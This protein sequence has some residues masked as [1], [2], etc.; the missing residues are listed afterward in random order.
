MGKAK[1]KK[2]DPV[3]AAEL[4]AA[5]QAKSSKKKDEK[6]GGW[7]LSKIGTNLFTLAIVGYSC[8]VGRNMYGIFQPDFPDEVN[9]RP[10]TKYSNAVQPG[11]PLRARVWLGDAVPSSGRPSADVAPDWEFEFPYSDSAF[12][13]ETKTVPVRVPEGLLRRKSNIHI[14][15]EVS[16]RQAQRAFA[17]SHGQFIKYIKEPPEVPKW[18]LLSGERCEEHVEKT[19]GAR[20][21]VARGLPQLQ[22]RLVFDQMRYP[23]WYIGQRRD[24]HPQLFVD[25]FWLSDDQ[26][27][28]LNDTENAFDSTVSFG[29][30][31][32]GRWR[33]QRQMEQSFKVNEEIF[34]EDSEEMLQMRD[35]FANTHPYLLTATLV[36]SVLHIIFEFL[37]FKN[38]VAFFSGV[39]TDTLNTYISIQSIVVGIFCQI[40]L[41][42]YLW[43]EQAN[44]LVLGTSAI[45]VLIDCWKVQRAMT[46]E[47]CLAFG[48]LPW[49]TL[50]TKGKSRSGMGE[51]DKLA[52]YYLSVGGLPVIGCYALYTLLYDC[53]KGWYSYVL[54][55]VATVVYA[56]G[57]A[58]MTPQLFINYKL[59]S[60]AFLPWRKFIYRA[61]NTFIDD[62][63]S[64][65]VR[66]PTMHRIGCFRDDIVFLIYL[67]QRHIYPED[68]ARMFD[69]D[70]EA[71]TVTNNPA[72]KSA[73]RALAAESKKAR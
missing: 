38:D 5:E 48:V 21:E 11:T 66:M 22:I 43:D 69:E 31:S 16:E 15:A 57:F 28:K 3:L 20:G 36:V 47:F 14:F 56:A 67:Y 42:L 32:G 24:Y 30:M 9:G 19:Y 54:Y 51:Y 4:A 40:V 8:L 2:E 63:F 6:K 23:D 13:T 62:L 59:K 65:I 64:F 34:G 12:E 25:E 61:L 60:V 49:A 73:D 26:L 18:R 41:M 10:V 29:L 70:D 37:A 72:A 7:S 71:T 68:K 45:A 35:L 17:Q 53:H 44:L 52:T 50:S 39:D 58:L 55:S 33:F 46:L 1:A 27:I